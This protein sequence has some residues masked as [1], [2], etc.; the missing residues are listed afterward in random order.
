[1]RTY[2]LL[3]VLILAFL[4][5]AS[6]AIASSPVAAD[7]TDLV[8]QHARSHKHN[9]SPAKLHRKRKSCKAKSHGKKKSS[10]GLAGV[11]NIT[12]HDSGAVQRGICWGMDDSYASKLK[13]SKLSWYHHWQGGRVSGLDA[14]GAEYVPMFWGSRYNYLWDQRKASFGKNLPKHII[15]QNEPDVKSQSNVDPYTAASDWIQQLGPYQKKGVKVTTP[16]I[17]YD[18]NWMSTFMNQLEKKGYKPDIIALHWYGGSNQIDSFKAYIQKVHN[19]WPN[20]PIWITEMGVTRT[21]AGSQ[22]QVLNFQREVMNFVD[23][24]GYVKRVAWI[25]AFIEGQAYDNFMSNMNA[26]FHQGGVQGWARFFLFGNSSSKRDLEF[27][28]AAASA[29]GDVIDIEDER[30]TGLHFEA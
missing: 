14:Q 21:G 25:G 3:T 27:V 13:G 24:S 9:S 8:L 1:M 12:V 15:A 17:V 30:N 16:Q 22:S 29:R 11:G 2:S 26:F 6:L 28:N 10:N 5:S 7:A 18:V 20:L 4:A 23:N 19:K